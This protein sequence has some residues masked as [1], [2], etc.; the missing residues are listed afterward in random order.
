MR[1]RRAMC[2]KKLRV[3]TPIWKLLTAF[4]YN[5]SSSELEKRIQGF[6]SIVFSFF[7]SILG[8]STP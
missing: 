3:F 6:V 8:P 1:K 7:T 4:I 2:R 5:S